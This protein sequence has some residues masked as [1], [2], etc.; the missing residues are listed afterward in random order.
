MDESRGQP[1]VSE[2]LGRVAVRL[3]QT[4]EIGTETDFGGLTPHQ[5]RIVGYIEANEDRGIIQRDVAEITGTR[6]ASV[7]SLLQGLER[8]GW[9]E[10]R[11]DPSDSRRKTLH[12]TDKARALVKGFEQRTW[13]AIESRIDCFTD[14]ERRTLIALLSRLDRHLAASS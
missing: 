9:L 4:M 13:G 12:V 3:R 6:P 5:A 10:R 8:D 1:T 7:S 14:E 11:T 2:L